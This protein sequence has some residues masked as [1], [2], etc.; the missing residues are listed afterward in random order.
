MHAL[1]SAY[2]LITHNWS[3]ERIEHAVEEEA[4]HPVSKDPALDDEGSFFP[5][6]PGA[7]GKAGG[8]GLQ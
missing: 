2:G 3:L 6:K 8:P 4:T 5:P 7:L 1:P